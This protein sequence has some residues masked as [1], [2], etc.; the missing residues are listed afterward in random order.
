[1]RRPRILVLLP[2]AG[3]V[4][5]TAPAAMASRTDLVPAPPGNASA[6]AAQVGSLLDVSKTGATADSGTAS[7]SASVVRLGGEPLLG[8]GGSQVGDGQAAGALLDTGTSLPARVA[9][10]PWQAS[11]DG[12]H[13]STRHSHSS[14]AAA[15]AAVPDIAEA[16]VLTSESEASHTDDKSTA[17][18]AS[19]GLF[20][21]LLDAVRL[22]LL[23]SEGSTEG[24]GHS[25]LVGLNGTEI[26]TDE[27][28]GAS[29]LCGLDLSVAS[30]SCLTSSGGNGATNVAAEVA[31]VAAAL[32]PLGVVNPVSAFTAQ[33]TS[34]TGAG[35]PLAAPAPET[36]V[37]GAEASRDLAPGAVGSAQN[38]NASA[39]PRTGTAIASM[40]G[41][42][43]VLLL[44]GFALRRF[45]GTATVS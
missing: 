30:L 14:A 26:G 15:R 6:V 25:Y 28:L 42:A 9:V 45:R 11:A 32:E 44:L 27:Q 5:W 29:P 33:A 12:T 43:S 18:A 36:P 37:A 22:V 1:M 40:A 35:T 10:A 7:S 16:G 19:D 20:V 21:G 31:Q 17:K 8:L 39:L 38:E 24:R 2:V 41:L 3:L 34:G 4:L 13:T 23:H